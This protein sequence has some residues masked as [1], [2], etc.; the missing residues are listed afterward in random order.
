MTFTT[1]LILGTA[2]VLLVTVAVLVVGVD[3]SLRR[4][5][6]REVR[7][8]LEREARLVRDGLG[9]DSL[10]WRRR[11]RELAR[12]GD[13]RVTVIDRTGRVLA[14]SEVE[15][16][17]LAGV[18]N[19]ADRPEVQAALREGSGWAARTSGTV[20]IRF[21]YVAVRGG[22]GVIRAAF[23]LDQV[24][25]IVWRAQRPVLV[26]AIVALVLGVGLAVPFGRRLGLR[27]AE[28][29]AAAR[30][31]AQGST[32]TFP[33]S[34]IPDLDRLGSDLRD[35]HRQLA[36]RYE[37][38]QRKQSETAAIVEAM[39][40]GV[41]AAD[42]RGVVLTANPAA[43]R[44]LGFGPAD[45]LPEL[46]LLFRAR[47][48]RDLVIGALNGQQAPER[49]TEI[50]QRICLVTARPL[51]G[52]GAVVVLHDLTHLKRLETVRRDFVANASHELKT[53]LTVIAGYAETLLTDHRDADLTRRFAETI[54]SNARRMQRLVDDQLDLARIE[55]G[56]WSPRPQ[57]V[58]TE[59]VCREAWSL[60][61][62]KR[63]A[64]ARLVLDIAPEAQN[65]TADPQGVSQVL[66]NLLE[67]AI[68]YT[69]PDGT[70]TVAATAEG[71]DIRL[72]VSDTGPGI[73]SEH[74]P[75][76]FERFY[77]AD[78]G[79]GREQGGT[80]LGL[81]IVRHL[82][83]AHGGRVQAESEAARGTTIHCWFPAVPPSPI[84]PVPRQA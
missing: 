12:A 28:A 59:A 6:E 18:E 22:P 42:A 47:E 79:R 16:D 60:V 4:D 65:L 20:G 74:L 54:L 64:S 72:S 56:H 25:A 13:V 38:L 23:G 10:A 39:V 78:P 48:A 62:P 73:A 84:P 71:G 19:H 68:R 43:R 58:A 27:L 44:L 34:G 14:D 17:R 46:P 83:E 80:G 11:A 32:P 77:R 29:R 69:A 55:S 52:G 31:I 35:M 57:R 70:I 30:A 51:A 49:E 82:V 66:Q 50:G 53:P 9:V 63:G 41:L 5:L 21:M 81:A 2:L 26:G 36:E 37:A 1:R 76:I 33:R 24:D 7:R 8:A 3:R 67:N 61:A 45:R 75:R 40:E 15:D